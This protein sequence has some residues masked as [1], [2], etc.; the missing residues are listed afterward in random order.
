MITEGK[1]KNLHPLFWG[2][3]FILA[4]LTSVGLFIWRQ[5]LNAQ[6]EQATTSPDLCIKKATDLEMTGW[7]YTP[8]TNE[9]WGIQKSG[10]LLRLF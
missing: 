4:I 3:V 6:L 7:K 5:D 1:P 9:C 10:D 2:L 8:E